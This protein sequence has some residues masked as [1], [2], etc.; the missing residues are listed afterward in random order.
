[1]S[2]KERLSEA[3]W[4][5]KQSRWCCRVMLNGKR[6]AFYSSTPGRRGKRE[7]ERKADEWLA[8]GAPDASLRIGKL[9]NDFV[10]YERSTKGDANPT[11]KQHATYGRL[12]ILPYLEY[13]KLEDMQQIDWQTCISEPFAA[14]INAG[15]PK[16]R[17][18]LQNIRGA[19]TA[20]RTY[21][22]RRGIKIDTMDDLTIPDAAIIG[23]RH[24]LQPEDLSVL[25]GQPKPTPTGQNRTPHY[26]HAWR[27]QV[28]TGLRPGE[29]YG[30]Q[31]DDITPSGM[32]TIRRSVN[33]DANVTHGKNYRAH[34][35]F[36][37]PNAARAVLDDQR[38]YLKRKGIISPFV[39]P[40]AD[41]SM[42]NERKSYYAWKRFQKSQGITE[43]SLYELRHTMVSI[44][45]DVPDALLK[46]MVGHSQNMD[47]RGTYGHEIKI[48]RART[49][50]MIDGI[51]AELLDA[52]N[53]ANAR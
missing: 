28:L 34:R 48:N 47:T 42:G 19:L 24:V 43:C 17:K 25:F 21:C 1:M 7:A 53:D 33:V 29:I 11:Y 51:F 4:N 40:S 31:L 27:F 6:R 13:K 23:E 26:L 5:E 10:E 15:K 50:E 12:Y 18:T 8:D 36:L 44:N 2:K 22:S 39:F 45:A 52:N 35:T 41:G 14:S 3:I 49:A 30:L 9:W 32:I 37:L 20:F 46:P 16:A 38:E